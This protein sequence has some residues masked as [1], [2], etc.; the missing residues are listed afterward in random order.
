MNSLFIM[1]SKEER[2]KKIFGEI[3]IRFTSISRILNLSAIGG[4]ITV[5]R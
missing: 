2:L 4:H 3:V 5:N 1:I